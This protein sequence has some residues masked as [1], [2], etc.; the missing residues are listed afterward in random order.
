MNQEQIKTA[1]KQIEFAKTWL[2][3]EK[4]NHYDPHMAN[5]VLRD[6][7]AVELANLRE[8]SWLMHKE[9]SCVHDEV[10]H[11][12]ERI[13]KYIQGQTNLARES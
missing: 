3:K 13:E 8:L 10:L 9:G 5:Y 11:L 7:Q 4:P 6:T 12:I 2:D 1:R